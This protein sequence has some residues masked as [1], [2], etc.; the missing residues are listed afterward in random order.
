MITSSQNAETIFISNIVKLLFET[1]I[2]LKV[3]SVLLELCLKANAQ[4][5]IIFGV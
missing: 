4:N 5:C 2:A 1:K 3:Y